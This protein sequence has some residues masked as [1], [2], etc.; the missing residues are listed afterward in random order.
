MESGGWPRP[1]Q[2]WLGVALGQP[3]C[4]GKAY[5]STAAPAVSAPVTNRSTLV[6]MERWLLSSAWPP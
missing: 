2:A 5:A 1:K 4:C 3:T 6:R